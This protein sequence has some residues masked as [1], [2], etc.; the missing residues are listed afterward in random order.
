MSRPLVLLRNKLQSGL[1][2]Q[3]NTGDLLGCCRC[4]RIALVHSEKSPPK[5]CA[6]ALVYAHIAGMEQKTHPQKGSGPNNQSSP[7]TADYPCTNSAL[8]EQRTCGAIPSQQKAITGGMCYLPTLQAVADK[9]ATNAANSEPTTTQVCERIA[10]HVGGRLERN[11]TRLKTHESLIRKIA[12]ISA[13]E[14][15][16]CGEAEIYDALRY[17][18]VPEVECDYATMTCDAI[19]EF[20]RL[21]YSVRSK[22]YWKLPSDD[23]TY[24]GVNAAISAPNG[25]KFEMQFHTLQSLSATNEYLHKLYEEQRLI[26]NNTFRWVEL[27]DKMNKIARSIP[28]PEG[29]EYIKNTQW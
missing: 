27:N 8:G 1:P 11:N 28:V 18:M 6:T 5:L 29:I 25:T 26:D 10:Q 20:E 12:A 2:E 13:S 3:T 24:R 17:T 4:Q 9:I 22:N 14:K 16:P 23:A 21:G 19:N 7:H 15:I